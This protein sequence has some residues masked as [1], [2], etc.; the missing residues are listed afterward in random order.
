MTDDQADHNPEDIDFPLPRLS[1]MLKIYK[2]PP[3]QD[4]SPAWTLFHPLTNKYYQIGWMEFECIA[5]FAKVT[6]LSELVALVNKDTSLKIDKKDVMA[7]LHLL[8]QYKALDMPVASMESYEENKPKEQNFFLKLAHSYLFFSIPLVRPQTFLERAYPYVRFL[9]HCYFLNV[10]ALLFCILSIMTMARLDE[11]TH[12][13]V[14]FMSLEGVITLFATLFVIKIFHE[15]GHAFMAYRHGVAVPHMGIAFMVLY[16]VLY[17]ETSAAWQL[18][19]NRARKDIGLAGIKTELVLATYALLIWNISAPGMVQSMAFAIVGIAL[20]GSL[21]VNLNPLMRFDG[22]FVLSD[23]LGIENLHAK[24]FARAKWWIRKVIWDLRDPAPDDF[25]AKTGRF[26]VLFGL[27]TIIYRFFLFLG[28][29]LLVYWLFFKPL[30]LILM[31]L[32]LAWF[33]FMPFYRELAVWWG[34]KN[35]IFTQKRAKA[36]LLALFVGFLLLFLP[37][38][39][40]VHA[41]AMLYAENNRVIYP[42]EDAF[43]VDLRVKDGEFVKQGEVLALL[44]SDIL[45]RDIDFERVKLK[46][47]NARKRVVA[48]TNPSQLRAL[49]EEVRVSEKTLDDLNKKQERL[50]IRAPFNG[51]I[52]QDNP[53][54]TENIMISGEQPLFSV[55]DPSRLRVSAYVDEADIARLKVGQSAYF[56]SHHHLMDKIPLQIEDVE[57]T[58]QDVVPWKDLASMHAGPI[59]GEMKQDERSVREQFVARKSLYTIHFKAFSLDSLEQDQD[60]FAKK[61][62]VRIHVAASIPMQRYFHDLSALVIR[63]IGFN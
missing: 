32:E 10:T 40:R 29:A 27:A 6:T 50:L 5:R 12:T 1:P 36:V 46:A 11:F 8:Q 26:L 2:A 35:D 53:Y 52:R 39:G 44:K 41:P 31:I 43:I 21:F 28:I 19:D 49:N 37:I 17:T 34:R 38:S 13:F 55:V 23:M 45:Q 9:G 22:Y 63:E 7:V 33:I 15:F 60:I 20:L 61:G 14:N 3:K 16:P 25:D 4:G 56:I 30:G 48:A 51:Y 24:G 57:S 42:P 18:S 59:A 62:S 47:L 58:G 54:L